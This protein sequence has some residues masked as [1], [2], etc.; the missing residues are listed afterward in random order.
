M[1]NRFSGNVAAANPA[2]E[3]EVAY[4]PDDTALEEAIAI[5]LGDD[6]LPVDRPGEAA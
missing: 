4:E 5:L 2:V 3:L 1:T 6:A